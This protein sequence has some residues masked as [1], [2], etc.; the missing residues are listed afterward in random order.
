MKSKAWI[1]LWRVEEIERA[2]MIS[3]VANVVERS[4]KTS[5]WLFELGGCVIHLL[6]ERK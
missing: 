4:A 6:P 1:T 3:M 5:R 2:N